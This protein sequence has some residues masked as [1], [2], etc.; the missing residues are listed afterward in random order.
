MV[1]IFNVWRASRDIL[2]IVEATYP[3]PCRSA[4]A[5]HRDPIDNSAAALVVWAEPLPVGRTW[6]WSG[7]PLIYR[8]RR[9]SIVKFRRMLEAVEGRQI[10]IDPES[11]LFLGDDFGEQ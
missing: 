7:R 6:S 1:K 4:G 3:V 8:G 10:M 9:R 5:P 2:K 11:S